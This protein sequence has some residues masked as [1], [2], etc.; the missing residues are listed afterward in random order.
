MG[1]YEQKLY[2]RRDDGGNV[3]KQTKAQYCTDHQHV[4]T[5]ATSIESGLSYPGRSDYNLSMVCAN[6]GEETVTRIIMVN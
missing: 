2:I 5:D 1:A 6:A 3:A 4:N